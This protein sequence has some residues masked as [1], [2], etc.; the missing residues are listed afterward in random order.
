MK[1]KYINQKAVRQRINE[2]GKWITP[3]GMRKLDQRVDG[4]IKDAV[5]KANSFKKVTEVEFS[6]AT[7]LMGDK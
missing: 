6:M 3:G 4:L 1:T 5:R 2:M 7:E